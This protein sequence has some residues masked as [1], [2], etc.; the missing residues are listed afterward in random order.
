MKHLK[1]SLQSRTPRWLGGRLSALPLLLFTLFAGSPSPAQDQI[2]ELRNLDLKAV[3][4][5]S[6]GRSD[7]GYTAVM[8]IIYSYQGKND[9]RLRDCSFEI[10][11]L[12]TPGEGKPPIRISFGT[13]KDFLT[14]EVT[15]EGP[16]LVPSESAILSAP[17]GNGQ[18]TEGTIYLPVKVGPSETETIDRLL[19]IM[20]VFANPKATFEVELKG[21]G[22]AALRAGRGWITQQ[23][24]GV[25]FLFSPTIQREVLFE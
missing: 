23:G 19:Q 13:T 12:D 11:I 4:Q 17:S 10:S 18:V 9:L 21:G 3:K 24:V 20:N 22:E 14:M 5:I 16:R 1:L 6:F 7:T 8:A 2:A 15:E 25:E